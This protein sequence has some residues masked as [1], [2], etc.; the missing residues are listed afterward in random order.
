MSTRP[1]LVS[2]S[3]WWAGLSVGVALLA[4]KAMRS[5]GDEPKPAATV[6]SAAPTVPACPVRHA[7]LPND[8]MGEHDCSCAPEAISGSV[9]G[10]EIYTA[11]S[12]ICAAA[13]HAGA[14]GAAGGKVT[15][16]STQGCP[17]YEGSERDGI[18]TAAW[19]AFE[20]SFF[21]PGHGNGKCSASA[22][23]P[24]AFKE[25]NEASL[26][27]NCATISL[28]ASVWGTDIYTTDSNLCAAAV[29]AGAITSAGGPIVAQRADGCARYEGSTR[30]GVTSRKWGK[31]QQSFFFPAKGEGKCR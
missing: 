30:H 25:Q 9:W 16:R 20:R 10:T 23:C 22:T 3:L 11:D 24:G 17:H 14:I 31:Y 7:E 21:F 28:T 6:A 26:S 8:G 1:S 12:S 2:T 4:C 27:C 19:D 15:V 13:R 5:E 18:T 29:H